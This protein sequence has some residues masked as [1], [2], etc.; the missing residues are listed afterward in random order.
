[1]SPANLPPSPACL[2]ASSGGSPGAAPSIPAAEVSG[3]V[4][5]VFEEFDLAILREVVRRDNLLTLAHAQE[6]AHLN[7]RR[8][9]FH[10]APLNIPEK[11]ALIHSEAS[12]ALE[13]YRTDP[14]GINRDD[15]PLADPEKVKPEGFPSEIAD[16]VIRCLDLAGLVGFDLQREVARKMLYNSTRPRMHGGKAC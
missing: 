6:I 1:M 4:D 5:K 15:D 16:I 8:K 12:E 11:I 9:G 2:T 14:V 10:D 13:E 7:S 3:H